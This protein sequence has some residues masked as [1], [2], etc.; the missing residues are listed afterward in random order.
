M[1]SD[2]FVPFTEYNKSIHHCWAKQNFKIQFSLPFGTSLQRQWKYAFFGTKTRGW[3]S[4]SSTN[5]KCTTTNVVMNQWGLLWHYIEATWPI[6]PIY[7][8]RTLIKIK[9]HGLK[10]VFLPGLNELRT[11]TQRAKWLV[12][13]YTNLFMNL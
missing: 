7:D 3:C 5:V 12:K 1:V 9:P 6:T 8:T 13:L 2:F 10:N 4:F 11:T